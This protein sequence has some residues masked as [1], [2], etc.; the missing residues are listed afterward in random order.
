MVDQAGLS[1][2]LEELRR[3]A[4]EKT[5]ELSEIDL[6]LE[7]YQ[8]ERLRLVHDLRRLQARML[9]MEDQLHQNSHD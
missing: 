4:V 6:M 3:E 2:L 7:D 9:E 1:A 5:R 8:T